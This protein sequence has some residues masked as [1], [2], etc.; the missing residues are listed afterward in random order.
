[1]K[2]LVRISLLI[3]FLITATGSKSVF[4]QYQ[5]T[6]LH[7]NDGESQLIDLGTGLED[8]GGVA[9]FKTLADQQKTEASETGSVIMLTSGDNF[10][11]GPE[12]SAGIS[13]GIFYDAVALDYMNYDA[14]CLGNHD[15]DFGPSI[16]AGFINEFSMSTPPFLSCNVDFSGEADLQTLMD[17]GK[18]ATSTTVTVDGHI[19]GVVGATTPMLPYISSPGDVVV[20]PDV[21]GAIQAE[22]DALTNNG[23]DFIILISHLQAVEE[24]LALLPSLSGIDIMIA[25]GGDELL[26]NENDLLI[27]GDEE[28]IYG[29][30]P[31]SGTDSDGNT[32]YVVTTRGNYSYLGKLV[33][34]VDENG[35]VVSIDES[36]G[37]VRVVGGSYDDAVIPDPDVQTNVVDPVSQYLDNLATNVVATSEVILDGRRSSIRF[38]ETNEGDMIADALLWQA[39][40]V[41]E[42]Y[43]APSASIALLNS[44]GIRN[45]TEIPAGNISELETFNML[46]FSN[47]VAIVHEVSPQQFKNILENSVSAI[48]G[49]GGGTGRFAQISGF[50]YSYNATFQARTYDVDGNVIEEGARVVDVELDD[51]TVIVENGAVLVSAPSVSISTINFLLRGGDQ[52]PFEEGQEYTNIGFSYQQALINFI[53]DASGLNGLIA[54]EVYPEG[55]EDRIN[56]LDDSGVDDIERSSLP[57]GFL[58]GQNYPNPFNPS[59]TI[60]YSLKNLSSVDIIVYDVLGCEVATLYSGNKPAGD[61][62]TVWNGISESGVSVTSGSY[63]VNLIANGKTQTRRMTLVK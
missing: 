31:L 56:R 29:T 50:S 15:F 62:T 33:V 10:L 42:E 5:L 21:A 16:L 11:A 59:T 36:S 2:R 19:V 30:Y 7:N 6:I 52:Y 25:G 20:D 1:M 37:P 54:E 40:Q 22:V 58:L 13:N 39:N 45:D 46:P 34:D 8:F 32:V 27:P 38:A 47:F 3:T 18:I 55:G 63:Y 49:D 51:G 12:F 14:L 53:V 61:Y 48:D 43:G 4:A 35:Q 9:R 23:V 26:A 60:P 41:H 17:N 44:G 57:D 28:Q 24:D